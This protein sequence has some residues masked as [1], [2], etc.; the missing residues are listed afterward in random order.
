MTT[1]TMQFEVCIWKPDCGHNLHPIAVMP[2]MESAGRL[3][4]ELLADNT[5]LEVRVRRVCVERRLPK[6]AT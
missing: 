2:Y 5:I 6:E 1:T 4:A 3:V